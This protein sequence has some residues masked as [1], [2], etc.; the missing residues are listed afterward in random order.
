M[1]KVS[2]LACSQRQILTCSVQRTWRLVLSLFSIHARC[3]ALKK[4]QTALFNRHCAHLSWRKAYKRSD[5]IN[6]TICSCSSETSNDMEVLTYRKTK[7][8]AACRY[9]LP[10]Y[11][12]CFM[13]LVREQNQQ[14]RLANFQAHNCRSFILIHHDNTPNI[15]QIKHGGSW[16]TNIFIFITGSNFVHFCRHWNLDSGWSQR[17]W[18]E[19]VWDRQGNEAVVWRDIAW[20]I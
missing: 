14:H 7:W 3:W 6:D 16:K 4:R 12:Y 2:N 1:R 11:G 15:T 17:F 13:G 20:E 9:N 10:K 19:E 18:T 8:L 5:V